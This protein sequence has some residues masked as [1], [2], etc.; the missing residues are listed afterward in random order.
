MSSES[1]ERYRRFNFDGNEDW[2]R[3]RANLVFPTG[4]DEVSLTEKYRQ[5]WYQVCALP[6]SS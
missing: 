4:G 2:L 5:K 3:Y 1:W 6:A